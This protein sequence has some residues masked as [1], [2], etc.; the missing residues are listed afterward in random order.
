M[1]FVRKKAEFIFSKCIHSLSENEC[2]DFWKCY[3]YKNYLS[4]MCKIDGKIYH[5]KRIYSDVINELLGR[6]IGEYLGDDKVFTKIIYD[7]GFR[8]SL[9]SENFID[10]NKNYT[11]LNNNIFHKLKFDNF[12]LDIYDIDDFDEIKVDDI[13]YKIDKTDFERLKYKLKMMVI[14]DY[15]RKHSDRD[16]KNFMFEYD[17]EHCRLMPLYDF[18][19]SFLEYEEFFHNTFKFDLNDLKVIEYIRNDEQF[20]KL[21]NLV[22]DMNM[23]LIFEKMFDEYPVRMNVDEIDQYIGI[24]NEKKDEIKAYKLVR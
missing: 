16:F 23:N 1:E 13:I 8:Y 17:K 2:R 14:S 6:I 5:K 4:Y 18:E 7:E 22:M 3:S 21:L 11:N 12:K 24:I 20:Q 15:V 10:K 19:L 9:L